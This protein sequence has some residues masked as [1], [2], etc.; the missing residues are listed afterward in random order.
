MIT[1]T[2]TIISQEELSPDIFQM[3]LYAPQMAQEALPGQFVDIYCS[4]K[5]KLLP[6]PISLFDADPAEGTLSLNYAVV[7]KGP[8]EISSKAEG[9]NIRVTGP[10][11][12][13]FP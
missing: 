8:E 5:D 2:F 11:G 7:G 1:D 12:H 4:S 13:G 9:D 3:V 6:R 10:L